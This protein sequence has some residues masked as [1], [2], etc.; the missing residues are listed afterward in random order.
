MISK[1]N[2]SRRATQYAGTAL[3]LILLAVPAAAQL[4]GAGKDSKPSPRKED[5]A[6]ELREKVKKQPG[7]YSAAGIRRAQNGKTV[8]PEMQFYG[9]SERLS[10]ILARGVPKLRPED[11]MLQESQ[12]E[13]LY[14]LVEYPTRPRTEPMNSLLQT[15]A[16]AP[17]APISGVSFEGPGAGLG[18]FS[19]T[20][21]PPDTTLAVGPNHVIAW[22]NSQF[23]IFNKTGSV[24][25][26]PSNGNTLFTGL[27]NLCAT[28]NRGDPILQYDR[29]ADRWILSQF[30]F[31]V[32]GSNPA[33]PYLQCFAISTTNDPTGSYYRYTVTF[34]S[35]SPSGFNDYGK[36]GIWNDGYYTSYNIF[37]GTP[38]GSNTGVGL[39]VSDR[40]KMLAG[41]A[42]ATTLCA[43]ITFYG[44]GGSFIPADLEGA[45]LPSDTTRG[46]IFIRQS[47]L[48]ALRYVR[49]KPDFAAGTVA[50]ND[51]WGGATGSYVELSLPTTTRPCNGSGGT[52]VAQPGT[53][54][55]LDT[56]GDRMMYRLSF[57]NRGGVESMVIN[58]S[59]DPD[60]AG[61]RSAAV[62]WYEIRNPLG[63]PSDAN[64][65][66]RPFLYQNGT[67]DPGSAGNRWMA[68]IASDK[69]GNLLMGYSMVNA[70]TT[71]YPSV[72]I[73]GRSQCDAINSMQAEQIAQAGSGSQTGT[74]TRWGDYTTI[75]VDPSDDLTF[76]YIGQY[77]SAN[78]T[79]NWRTRIVSFR[80]PTTTANTNGDFNTAANWSNGVPSSS[81][82]GIVPAGRTMT[83]NSATTVCN[84]DVQSGA[85]LAMN[86]D[87]TVEGALT[88]GTS[89]NTGSSTL[90]LGCEAT[91]SGVSPS[92]Y[93]RGSVAKQYCRTGGFD[94][95]VGTASGY[96]PVNTNVTTLTTNPSTLSVTAVGNNRT[97]MDAAQSANRYWALALTGAL[98]TNL[99]FNY[100]DSD[101]AG[102]E[103][104]YKLYR[105]N[106]LTS[107]A[108]T[109]FT[110]NTAANTV[111]V[112]GITS[113]SDWT[114]GNLAPT[115]A[116]GGV[117]GRVLTSEGAGL[118]NATVIITDPSGAQRTALTG[119]FGYFSIEGLATG[120]SYTVTVRSKTYQFAPRLIFLDDDIANLELIGQSPLR[121]Q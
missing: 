28:T 67:Y 31:N 113:F 64:T 77:L 89:V 46:G 50:I 48:P 107:T 42:S 37:G 53:T 78:G 106:A 111:S 65:S 86:A 21:A 18:G 109:P 12:T 56:L 20:G 60:G 73:T 81:V 35:T 71:T 80:F 98:T 22:V 76:W 10:D 43:P 36:L 6:R 23:V 102:T 99:V 44:G 58:Q 25:A 40:T 90:T 119:A 33:A 74:L 26:G 92:V 4:A 38:A 52:C 27:G 70:A 88:L 95:P 8:Q 96:S 115:A 51:G 24:L 105:W 101:V 13:P 11:G 118:R 3:F 83:V 9:E 110:L 61:S 30:A 7:I 5:E 32:S 66:K 121:R 72:A 82:S 14:E 17:F 79:F 59:V 97:G 45:T 103:S 62:R 112:T 117:S 29:L 114:I 15:E 49:L 75:Q 108:V 54:N 100:L 87:L 68:S 39:C 120:V 19:M 116:E 91:V 47:T 57:R 2:L 63:N 55:T 93:V 34:S 69:Y 94:F 1:S 16:S 85:S 104:G 41:D 84:L